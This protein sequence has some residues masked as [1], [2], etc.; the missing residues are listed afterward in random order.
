MPRT[1]AGVDVVA[2]FSEV[3]PG[4]VKVSLRSTGRVDDRRGRDAARRRRPSPRGRRAAARHAAPTRGRGSCPSSP[5]AGG[6]PVAGG[7]E[8][9]ER[10][11]RNARRV[12]VTLEA[13]RPRRIATLRGRGLEP[14]ELPRRRRRAS[15]AVAGANG[16][17]KSTL[18]RILAGLLRPTRGERTLHVAAAGALDAA[19]ARAGMRSASPRP[20]SPSTTSSPRPRT[21]SF[22]G[23]ARGLERPRAAV[24]RSARARRPRARAQRPRGG[25]LLGHEAAAAARLRP[26]R[27]ARA[28]LLSTSP[29]AISTRKGARLAARDRRGGA[30][31]RPGA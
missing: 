6:A 8:D 18:L 25:A 29:A 10:R 15:V 28:V 16:A 31:R 19:G 1:I 23:E 4:K 14:V 21:S 7:G 24:A 5:R 2:L 22:A 13:A 27:T 3:E 9:D 11:A 20:T 30:A 26:A 12:A 17:G